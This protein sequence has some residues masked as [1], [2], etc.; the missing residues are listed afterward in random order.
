LSSPLDELTPAER[1]HLADL[2]FDPG[3][4]EALAEQVRTGTTRSNA[5]EGRVDA[6][7]PGDILP[8]A[9]VGTMEGD[10][11][12]DAGMQLLHGGRAGLIVLNGGMA[13]RFGGRVKGV[14]DALPGRSF[15]SLQCDRLATV[16]S[17]TGLPAPLLVM[18]SRATEEATVEHLE[19]NRFF[20]LDRDDVRCF[21]QTGAPRLRADGSL[22]RDAAG[23][24]SVY[25]PGHGDM[26]PCLRTSG[27]LSWARERGVE[28][29]LMANVDNLGA[30]LD[31][32]LL[33]RFAASGADMMV[34]VAPKAPGDKGGA[35]AK[36]D[37][38]LA[39]VEGFAFPPDFDQDSIDV[40]N[41]NTLWF[42]TEALD[43]D[44]PLRW[45]V[46]NKEADGEPV[47][48]FERLIG[49]L[50]WF[51]QTEW[52]RVSRDRFRPVKTP[53]DLDDLQP[54]LRAM[55]GTSLRVL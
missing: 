48:Q 32:A 10:A 19:A 31:P 27:G 51:L 41:T 38:R 13:T 34:E 33:G 18:N 3:P 49:Q 1:T 45:Y 55:F 42:R 39:I 15:L 8:L 44:F 4:F 35:P 43:A 22:Y 36:V 11:L 47:V 50:S 25:G 29:L 17:A 20:G 46:V 26:A 5:V 7:A 2:G 30:T 54:V 21:R 53:Q 28:Y 14:V 24:L 9:P 23:A 52:V 37:G 16:R 12:V 40:F 6:P